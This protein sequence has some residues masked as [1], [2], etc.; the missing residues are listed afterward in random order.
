MLVEGPA[1]LFLIPKLVKRV[2]NVDLERL[3]ISVVPIHGV[4]FAAY[5]KLFR[6]EGMRKKCAVVTDG[7]LAPS[8]AA[9]IDPAT[10]AEADDTP[11]GVRS[12]ELAVFE[13]EY[14]KVFACLTTF[15]RTLA[16]PGLLAML[17]KTC[18]ELGAPRIRARIH[19]AIESLELAFNDEDVHA[20]LDGLD[21]AVLNTAK[22][23]GKARFA[24]VAS[25]HADLATELPQYIR[26]AVNWL[27]DH[28]SD[29]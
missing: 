14:L 11:P 27:T 5:A 4:H 9:E 18:E 2:M 28:E 26:D 16:L 6:Q 3:G 22:R 17:E 21:S 25:K 12:D 24:Q 29:E 23:F 13:N 10:D 15:E 19:S 8:D 1:E 7:D 20:I